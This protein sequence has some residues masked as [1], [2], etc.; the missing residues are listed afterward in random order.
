M[1]AVHSIFL[2]IALR[3]EDELLEDIIVARHDAEFRVVSYCQ[4]RDTRG[5]A[6]LILSSPQ[7]P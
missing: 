4:T 6:Y 2:I 7:E 3:L 1:D 5:D